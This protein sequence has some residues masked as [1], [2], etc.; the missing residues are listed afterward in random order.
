MGERKMLPFHASGHG[1]SNAQPYEEIEKGDQLGIK[2]EKKR[3]G[4][5]GIA[6]RHA[7]PAS[8][9]RLKKERDPQGRLK[10]RGRSIVRQSPKTHHCFMAS[11]R[12]DLEKN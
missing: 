3:F 6:R 7:L 1:S 9:P 12:A 10:Q 11:K 4:E 2:T 5:T 8:S